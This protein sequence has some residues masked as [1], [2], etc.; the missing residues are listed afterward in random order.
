M[1][2]FLAKLSATLLVSL[3]LA[4]F[5]LSS[6]LEAPVAVAAWLFCIFLAGT[7]IFAV[8]THPLGILRK[9]MQSFE[10]GGF[11]DKIPFAN[12][13]A[14]DEVSELGRIYNTMAERM[15]AQDR[16]LREGDKLRRDLIANVSHDL[17]TPLAA[18]RGYVET[19]LVKNGSLSVEE[20]RLYLEIAARQ[21]EHLGALIAELFE[22]AKLEYENCKI[23]REPVLLS[24]LAQDVVQKFEL[25]A[26]EKQIK[27]KLLS[28]ARMPFVQADLRLIERALENLIGNAI[29]Y[30]PVG[31]DVRVNLTSSGDEIA[32][33]VQD[34]GTGV[35]ETD[36]PFIFD[37][38]YRVDKTH[39]STGAGLGL[40][41]T[42]RIVELHGSRISAESSPGAG[43]CFSFS[44][45]VAISH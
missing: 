32:V 38:F 15:L 10:R 18:L 43:A 1:P 36:L 21:S 40:A 30:S 11:R 14:R 6:R 31:G 7:G 16:D 35:P 25:A 23:N 34:S 45:P 4:G 5:A 22:L 12:V 17:R 37:R 27:L 28:P 44:L 2:N 9:S 26:S 42:K 19:L 33:E 20:R 24:E 39:H 8:V 3:I 41:I 29:K 13:S